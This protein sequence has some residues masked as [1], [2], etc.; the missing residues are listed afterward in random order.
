M[1]G[2]KQGIKRGMDK[3]LSILSGIGFPVFSIIMI[4]LLLPFFV[5]MTPL[6]IIAALFRS[7]T[8][9]KD[10]AHAKRPYAYER[11]QF[12]HSEAFA[13]ALGEGGLFANRKSRYF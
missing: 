13:E 10:E 6:Y 5:L 4:V 12:K 1:T 11:S 8:T 3:I 9:R 7:G 2:I